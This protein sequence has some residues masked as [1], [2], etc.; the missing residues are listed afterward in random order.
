M[1]GRGC[2]KGEIQGR[3]RVFKDYYLPEKIDFEI[4]VAKNTDPGWTPLL[5]LCKG[6]IIENGGILSHAAIV[7]RELGI[8]TIIGVKNATKILKSG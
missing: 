3:I 2:T 7:S 6:L 4:A 5:G 8:P 1:V